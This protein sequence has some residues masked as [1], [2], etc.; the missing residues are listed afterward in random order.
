MDSG[1]VLKLMECQAG[2]REEPDTHP[3]WAAGES[4]MKGLFV[5]I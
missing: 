1:L 2:P 5:R 4:L 3:N